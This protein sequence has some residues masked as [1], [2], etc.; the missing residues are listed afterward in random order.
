MPEI[1][2]EDDLD[3]GPAPRVHRVRRRDGGWAWIE[4]TTRVLLDASGRVREVHT[5]SR[6]VSERVR[7]D[8]ERAAV[9]RVTAAVAEGVPFD[10]LAA[11][12]TGEAVG[13]V[14]A[15]CAALVRLHAGEGMVLGAAG[16]PLAVGDRMAAS[17]LTDDALV[18]P[19]SVEGAPWG[20]I[21]ARGAGPGGDDGARTAR[22]GRLA[23]LVGL[24]VANARARERLVALATTDPLTGLANHGAFH[25]RL[26]EEC[27]RAARGGAPLSLILIDLDH[28]KRVN[29]TFG[30]Q[31]GDDVLREVSRRLRDSARRGD[32]TA[33]VG[34]EEL[35]WLLPS[36]DL[37]RG[38]EAAERLRAA[39]SGSPFPVA[40]RLT[41][42]LGVAALDGGAAAGL[43]RRADRA[44]YRAKDEGRDACVA[45][46]E[47]AVTEAL[48]E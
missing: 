43:T 47:D 15:E 37:E 6:D 29:D 5:D 27:A 33:R 4:T 8:A 10:R 7:A 24:A 12:V 42:S 40:G 41:A 16:P 35:A 39:I 3:A 17:D 13:L 46:R 18:A 28:F 36:T 44:L 9:T 22:L 2:P 31:V 48:F 19:V 23:P 21:L 14:G 34:G 30:H 1:L 25:R 38:L 45:W 26:E 32:V 11:L 20:V